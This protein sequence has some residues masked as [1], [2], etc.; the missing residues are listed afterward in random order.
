VVKS[1]EQ[2]SRAEFVRLIKQS[3]LLMGLL[4]VPFVAAIVLAG[5]VVFPRLLGEAFAG[6]TPVAAFIAVGFMVY[7]VLM[8]TRPALIA[9]TRIKELNVVSLGMVLASIVGLLL[10]VPV[11]GA[12][13]AAAVRG[14]TMALQNGLLLV[15]F[16]HH[17]ARQKLPQE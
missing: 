1:Y 3:S 16:Q 10:V 7:G 6:V 9:L 17:L 2:N 13:G 12:A 5:S 8:W 4:T 15:V 14:G 11:Y